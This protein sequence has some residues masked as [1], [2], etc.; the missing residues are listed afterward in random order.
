MKKEL[1]VYL[2]NEVDKCK[3]QIEEVVSGTS[4]ATAFGVIRKGIKS[5]EQ[6]RLEA[7]LIC[8]KKTINFINSIDVDNTHLLKNGKSYPVLTTPGTNTPIISIEDKLYIVELDFVKLGLDCDG[9]TV[10]TFVT[11]FSPIGFNDTNV[12]FACRLPM[13]TGRGFAPIKVLGLYND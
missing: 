2:Q 5:I 7:Q 8:L 3:K 6:S 13:H 12:T 4:I 10:Y 9:D 1:L 11:S